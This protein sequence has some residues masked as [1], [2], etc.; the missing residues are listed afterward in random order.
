MQLD[1]VL[2]IDSATIRRVVGRHR[3]MELRWSRQPTAAGIIARWREEK[4]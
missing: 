2:D 1:A 3:Y 4:V